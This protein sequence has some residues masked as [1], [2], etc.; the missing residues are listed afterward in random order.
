MKNRKLKI[1]VAGIIARYPFGGVTWCSLMYLIGLRALGHDVYYL[2][3]TGECVYDFEQNTISL[4]SS[5]GLRYINAA[6]SPYGFG[7]RWIFVDYKKDYYGK[8]QK[9]TEEICRDAD[10]FINLSGGCWFWRDE[11]QKIPCKIFIDS[12]PAFTQA[13]L[14]KAEPWYVNFF[15][16]FDALFTFGRNL[17]DADCTIPETPFNWH[18]T[19]QPIVCEEWATD[20]SPARNVFTTIM[21]WKNHSFTDADGNKDKQFQQ[22]LDLPSETEQPIELAVNGAQ[23]LLRSHGWKT[24]GGMD[25]SRDLGC[26]RDYIQN[27]KAEFS[28]A[29]HLYV[30][31]RSGWFSDRSEC[32]LAAGRPV[33]VQDTGFSKYLPTGEGLLTFNNKTEVLAGIDSINSDY[34]RHS[35]R[36]REIALESFDAKVILPEL[37]RNA[38]VY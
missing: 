9:Q 24:V 35:R 29:K 25:V 7:D 16:E 30:A 28:V 17:G 33:L 5:Y 32:Y 15:K 18:K 3:D 6:L 12:D 27:S 11:Y 14:A 38:G 23:D 34:L 20:K 37:L 19:W 10:L 8:T 21:T 1:I 13:A 26:Y 4:D 36:A 2:E 31:T 22:F